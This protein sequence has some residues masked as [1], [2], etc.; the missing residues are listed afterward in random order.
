MTIHCHHVAPSR[1]SRRIAA[2][3]R[4]RYTSSIANEP[5]VADTMNVA[6]AFEPKIGTNLS[7]VL[8]HSE[9]AISPTQPTTTTRLPTHGVLRLDVFEKTDGSRPS[10]PRAK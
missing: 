1:S 6:N 3:Q 8:V 9:I 2:R 5:A 10:R 4:I 7:I